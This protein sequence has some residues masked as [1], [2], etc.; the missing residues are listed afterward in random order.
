MKSNKKIDMSIVQW[1]VYLLANSIAIPIVIGAIF[2]LHVEEV[3]S[4]M[5]RMFF[6]VGLSSFLQV[7]FGHRYP[8]ADGPAGSWVGIFVIY[9]SISAQQGISGMETLQTLSGGLLVSGLLLF[10]LGA[11]KWVKQILFLFTPVVTG[12]FLF[13]LAVQLSV[14]FFKG[15][16]FTDPN[17]TQVDYVSLGLSLFVFFIILLF[18]LKGKGWLKSYAILIGISLGWI[19][20][21]WLDKGNSTARHSNSVIELPKLF[22]WGIP[23]FTTSVL[24]TSVLFT[25]LLI[26]NT[27]AAISSAERVVPHS[28]KMFHERLYGGTMIG[29]LSHVLA[30][31]FA[32]IA[33]VPL[34]ATAGF[35]QITKQY[36]VFPFMVACGVMMSISFFPSV[37]GQ[38]AAL[39][40]P[41]AS[42]ALLATLIEMFKLSIRSLTSGFVHTKKAFLIGL[43]IFIGISP[44]VISEDFYRMFPIW[45]QYIAS[46]GLLLG[47]FL[48]I[49]FNQ[50][51]TERVIN[52]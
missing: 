43:P 14:V 3:S 50:F 38:L 46:N 22:E 12:S 10:L 32:T 36:R 23:T 35:I 41:I 39:P 37:V 27:I 13:I 34:P 4:L 20:Y 48:A 25:F 18:T 6:V 15:M 1:F 17:S 19:L 16:L 26:S 28:E 9:A 2:Q 33:V 40:L 52:S 8:I 44:M 7:K 21:V 11:T 45:I 51:F 49:L 24:I 5:Q 47:T 42:A 31:M 30:T 29:G